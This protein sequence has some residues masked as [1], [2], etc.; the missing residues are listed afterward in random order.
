MLSVILR[1]AAPARSAAS[2]SGACRTVR[3]GSI[4]NIVVLIA[5]ELSR[6][7]PCGATTAGREVTQGRLPATGSPGPVV[8]LGALRSIIGSHRSATV[9]PAPGG[10]GGGRR[11]ASPDP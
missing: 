11:D 2:R 5:V 1:V 6:P 7:G 8:T 9:P 4:R 10:G 3:R